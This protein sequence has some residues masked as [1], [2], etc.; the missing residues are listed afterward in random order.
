MMMVCFIPIDMRDLIPGFFDDVNE[1][2]F[3]VDI[4]IVM[5]LK[6]DLD[7]SL[8]T[9][10]KS[11]NAPRGKINLE[12][13][14]LKIWYIEY[15]EITTTKLI[16]ELKH[17][18]LAGKYVTYRCFQCVEYKPLANLNT[19]RLSLNDFIFTQEPNW[20][21][22]FFIKDKFMYDQKENPTHWE[23]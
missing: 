21:F 15:D 5:I 6:D 12:S 17:F 10:S 7:D 11:G 9:L 20:A 14:C 1:L 8:Y 18:S 16:D 22:V 3:G 19:L 4:H 2:I 13:Y 23:C